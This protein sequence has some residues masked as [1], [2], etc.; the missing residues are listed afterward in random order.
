[1]REA[2]THIDDDRVVITRPAAMREMEA[3]R[4]LRSG[5]ATAFLTSDPTRT[6]MAIG[7]H[8]HIRDST[9]K[10]MHGGWIR[11]KEGHDIVKKNVWNHNDAVVWKILRDLP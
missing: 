2:Y 11:S 4:A 6:G 8:P 1:M 7:A 5:N 3:I 10:M 9:E